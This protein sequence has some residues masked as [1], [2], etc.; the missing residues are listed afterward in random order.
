MRERKRYLGIS[1]ALLALGGSSF[2]GATTVDE[3]AKEND[4]LR[5]RIERLEAKEGTK[6]NS[7]E[8]SQNYVRFD[9]GFAYEMLDSTTKINRKQQLLLERKQDGTLAKNALYLGGSATPIIDF[10]KSNTEDKFGYLM[11]HPT[12]SNQRTKEV[13]EAVIHSAQLS[14][15]ANLGDWTSVYVEML[16]DPEQ[17]FG[18]GTITDLNRNQVQ[19]R[20]GYVMFGDLSQSPYYVAI[21]KMATPFGLTDTVNPFTAS[22]VWHAFGGLAYGVNGGYLANGWDINVMAIQ[23]GS[24][25]RAHH[26]PVDDSSVPSKLNNYAVDIN[27]TFGDES[28]NVLVGVS[29]TKG[30]AYCQGFPVVHFQPCADANGA[31]DFYA[32]YNSDNWVIQYEFAKTED[33]WPGTFNPAIPQFEASDVTSWNLGGKYITEAGG[34][35]LHI[36]FDYSVFEAGP[37]G[38]PW[39]MQ[40][41]IVFGVASYLNDSTK[42]FAEIIRTEGYAPLNFISG[43]GGPNV[44]PGETHSDAN[45]SSNILMLGATV[46]F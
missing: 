3:L 46:A 5:K 2:V 10:Q 8:A 43:G 7:N 19:V 40:E 26:V 4:D 39:E 31:Y 38:S 41:Q 14:L 16:Y 44:G 27:K 36:S 30:S 13:S 17:S 45:A 20:Q 25:F 28:S 37:D 23:G 42:L 32:Q 22:T 12:S 33:E 21:G 9:H 18:S 34:N 24:Q 35:P 29:Y 15:A 1:A 11:R 6:D